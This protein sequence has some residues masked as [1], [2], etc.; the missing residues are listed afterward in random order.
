MSHS[1]STQLDSIVSE[2]PGVSFDGKDQKTVSMLLTQGGGDIIE[3]GGL[4]IKASRLFVSYI[5]L[6]KFL[7]AK[8]EAPLR[9]GSTTSCRCNSPMEENTEVVCAPATGRVNQFRL[10]HHRRIL[11]ERLSLVLPRRPT[12]FVRE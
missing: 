11:I 10:L 12:C 5:S 8:Q 6:R 3:V 1:L 9:F 7:P 4:S 2:V